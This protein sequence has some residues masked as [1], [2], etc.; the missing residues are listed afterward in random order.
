MFYQWLNVPDSPQKT[1]VDKLNSLNVADRIRLLHCIVNG[2]RSKFPADH[3]HV[4]GKSMLR[5][6]SDF[7]D[8]EKKEIVDFLEKL[9]TRH[10]GSELRGV[11]GK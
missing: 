1:W 8:R 2:L 7:S 9:S 5:K 11:F 3:L 4:D 10:P 6:F